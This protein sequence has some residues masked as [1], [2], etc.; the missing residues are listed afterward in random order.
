MDLFFFE[1]AYSRN[2]GLFSITSGVD[3]LPRPAGF[4]IKTEPDLLPNP[5]LAG[6]SRK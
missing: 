3:L 2:P 6:F 1:G 4:K 5:L